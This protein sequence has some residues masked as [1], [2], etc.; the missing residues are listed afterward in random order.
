ML[1]TR[2]QMT[3]KSVLVHPQDLRSGTRA[4]TCPPCYA[5][6][7]LFYCIKA[8]FLLLIHFMFSNFI[9]MLFSINEIMNQMQNPLDF[10][11]TLKLICLKN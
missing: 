9:A 5:T 8:L 6:V 10:T 2:F 4:P 11:S 3:A 1:K 7:F